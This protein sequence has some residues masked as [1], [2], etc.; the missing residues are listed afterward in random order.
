[1]RTKK[2]EACGQR[3]QPRPQAPNQAYC[4]EPACQRTRRLR[5]QIDKRKNDPD[6]AENQYRAQLAWRM[7]NADYWKNYRAEHPDY[8]ERNR[9]NQRIRSRQELSDQKNEIAKMDAS[10]PGGRVTSGIYR[11]NLI[12]TFDIAKMG[13]WMVELRVISYSEPGEK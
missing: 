8:V 11:M 5:W 1:M 2:C 9:K 4:S 13:V 12:S 3:F 10:T 7:R 6:Y